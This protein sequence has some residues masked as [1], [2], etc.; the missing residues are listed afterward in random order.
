MGV[1]SERLVGS[2]DIPL[3][4]LNRNKVLIAAVQMISKESPEDSI[5]SFCANSATDIHLQDPAC[6]NS[7][8]K[9]PGQL[10]IKYG[11]SIRA[12]EAANQRRA[13]EILDP[14]IAYVPEVYRFFTDSRGIGYM[15]MEYVEGKPVDSIHTPTMRDKVKKMIEHFTSLSDPI[16]GPLGGGSSPA[17]IFGE[18]DAP[19]FFSVADVE[20]WINDRLLPRE[21]PISLT[22][23]PLQLC[24]LDLAPRN[25]LE[26]EDGSLCL[27]DWATAGYY[28]WFFEVCN[29]R[30]MAGKCNIFDTQ[31]LEIMR[32]PSAEEELLIG[33]VLKA[34]FNCHKYC[35]YVPS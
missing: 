17:L 29:Q 4:T 1:E 25:L 5:V 3:Q 19:E 28:P 14:E 7:V 12:N 8:I 26:R 21:T 34:W 27:I 32:K 35:V 10:L 2:R 13:R 23:L 9:L 31:L 6:T 20:T 15:L 22:G 16:P 30:I 11:P 33:T 24:H 18:E